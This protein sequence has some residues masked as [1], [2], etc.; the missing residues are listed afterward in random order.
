MACAAEQAEAMSLLEG[1]LAFAI[2]CSLW[3]REGAGCR[4]LA[5][6]EHLL[7][8][9]APV[10]ETARLSRLGMADGGC[11]VVFVPKKV[12]SVEVQVCCG[13]EEKGTRQLRVPSTSRLSELSTILIRSLR[14]SG[15]PDFSPSDFAH[16]YWTLHDPKSGDLQ[17]SS[18]QSS[19]S[20]A[21]WAPLTSEHPPQDRHTKA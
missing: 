15:L 5:S 12:V 8:G 16:C 4:T 21:P 20:G 6:L 10:P 7:G 3:Q 18:S 19:F 9:F 13:E 11:H 2:E 14:Q 1:S 17:R